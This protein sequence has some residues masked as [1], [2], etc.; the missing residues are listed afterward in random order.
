M[1]HETPTILHL[2]HRPLPEMGRIP[3]AVTTFGVSRSWLYKVAP[4]YPGLLK[5]LGH[6]TLVDFGVLR[7]ILASA[8]PAAVRPN[9]KPA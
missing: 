3:A 4:D 2:N 1:T 7:A 6:S 9:R 8:P 5:K